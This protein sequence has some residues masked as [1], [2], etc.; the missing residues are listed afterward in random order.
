MLSIKF[1]SFI[2]NQLDF[3]FLRYFSLS[4][5]TKDMLHKDAH[6]SF[7]DS[8]RLWETCTSL[9][10]DVTSLCLWHLWCLCKDIKDAKDKSDIFLMQGRKES[11]GFFGKDQQNGNIAGLTCRL[12]HIYYSFVFTLLDSS[13]KWF[14]PFVG[15]IGNLISR[16]L[17]DK[18]SVSVS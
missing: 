11:E 15:S 10:K 1:H 12:C 2:E 8:A 13:Q 17:Y 6:S 16:R 3:F 9:C 7:K 5:D 4:K 18:D 14:H